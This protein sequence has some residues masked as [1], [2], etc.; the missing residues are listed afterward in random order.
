MP[1]NGQPQLRVLLSGSAAEQLGRSLANEPTLCRV[2][3]VADGDGGRLPSPVDVALHVLRSSSDDLGDE[4]GKVRELSKAPLILAAYGEPN[5]IVETGLEVGAA[6]VLVLPQPPET[7]LFA[8][9]KAAAVS[10]GHAEHGKVVTVFSPKGGSGK[11]VLA[12]NLAVA[13]AP[14]GIDT[15]L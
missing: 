15:L 2:Q 13:S 10:T 8:I 14:S 4:I 5:G 9:R 6:D 11:T 12:T 1:H 7:L 3:A